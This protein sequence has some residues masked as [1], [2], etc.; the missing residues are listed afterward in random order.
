M[1][2]AKHTRIDED[3]NKPASL[4][5]GVDGV[6]HGLRA[7]L[8]VVALFVVAI[9]VAVVAVVGILLEIADVAVAA[10]VVAAVVVVVVV[11]VIAVVDAV[12]GCLPDHILF[13]A[14]VFAIVVRAVVE[15][16]IPKKECVCNYVR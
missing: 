1:S 5:T 6:T 2:A 16:I 3:A 9:F 11:V 10:A 7:A 4:S 12:S 8:L 15:P 14:P 13:L